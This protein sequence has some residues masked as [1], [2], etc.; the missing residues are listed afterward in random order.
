MEQV[1][2]IFLV[3]MKGRKPLSDSFRLDRGEDKV[4]GIKDN[5]CTRTAP[6]GHV[7]KFTLLPGIILE[8]PDW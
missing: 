6:L 4:T 1:I 5:Y 8:L 2:R 7:N 3:L